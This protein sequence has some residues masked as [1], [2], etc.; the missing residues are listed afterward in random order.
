MH[1]HFPYI[2]TSGIERDILLHSPTP[3]SPCATELPRTSTDVRAVPPSGP[4]SGRLVLQAMGLLPVQDSTEMED[5][6][7]IIALFDNILR[8]EGHGDVF[9]LR[10]WTSDDEDEGS[11]DDMMVDSEDD[12]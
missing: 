2:L 5:D 9:A 6:S 8:Q 4:E 7:G 12:R 11:A 10:R 1:P 3:N